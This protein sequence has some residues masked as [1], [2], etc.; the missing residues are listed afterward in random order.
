MLVVL[1]SLAP[2][3]VPQCGPEFMLRNIPQK[4]F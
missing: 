4:P 2:Y 1:Q 3:N